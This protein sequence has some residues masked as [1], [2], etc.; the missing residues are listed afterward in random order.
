[1][2]KIFFIYCNTYVGVRIKHTGK[3]KEG[4]YVTDQDDL[5]WR[6]ILDNCGGLNRND[7]HKFKYLNAQSPGSRTI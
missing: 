1:M 6:K 7:P 2:K 5:A 3:G 4:E